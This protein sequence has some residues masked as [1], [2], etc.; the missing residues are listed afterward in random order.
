MDIYP[1]QD[2]YCMKW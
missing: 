1:E 2:K